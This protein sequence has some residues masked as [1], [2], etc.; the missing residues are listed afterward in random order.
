MLNAERFARMERLYLRVL[1]SPPERRIAVLEE[2]CSD[3][4]ELLRELESLL[5]A[6]E[7]AGSFLWLGGV[8]GRALAKDREARYRTM[9]EFAEDLRRLDPQQSHG[10]LTASTNQNI[11]NFFERHAKNK[12]Y[13]AAAL[14]GIAVYT[15]IAWPPIP[16]ADELQLVPLTTFAASRDLPAFSPDGSRIAFSWKP[17]AIAHRH[18]REAG[19]RSDLARRN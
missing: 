1:D 18:L 15:W 6:R 9:R 10:V 17:P 14:A 5:E 13:L 7:H 12:W 2:S 4:P 3:D 16:P 11:R 8:V 19:G